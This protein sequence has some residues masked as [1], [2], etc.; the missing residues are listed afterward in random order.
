MKKTLL[1][2]LVIIVAGTIW[3]QKVNDKKTKQHANIKQRVVSHNLGSSQDDPVLTEP[4]LKEAS[5]EIS[6]FN[7]RI[8]AS[9]SYEPGS[10]LME[11]NNLI[12]KPRENSDDVV[13]TLENY[14]L[15]FSDYQI[16]IAELIPYCLNLKQSLNKYTSSLTTESDNLKE[17][18]FNEFYFFDGLKK[19]RFC[20][21]LGTE[22][23]PLYIYL[24]LARGGNRVAQLLL[25]DHLINAIHRGVVNVK[26][27]PMT[28]MEL[29]DES[30]NYLK[31]LAASGI[32][33]ASE[34]L[35]RL[36]SGR[37][38]LPKDPVL[39]YYYSYLSKMYER[40]EVVHVKGDELLDMMTE[41]QR[42]RALKMIKNL[43][44]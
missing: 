33:R 24:D 4:V 35:Y 3:F 41:N 40:F 15:N 12:S 19:T 20:E 1:L 7:E 30:V 34:R 8:A 5:N 11:V 21:N 38:I 22:T 39:E 36:Y 32:T 9:L 13:A 25:I 26:Q 23:D 6:L 17:T 37:D 27:D 18:S 16:Q 29:R 2:L 43:K 28:Y 10:E 14:F 31:S 42:A 44:K